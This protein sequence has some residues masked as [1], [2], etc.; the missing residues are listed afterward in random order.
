[1]TENT[2]ENPA[3]DAVLNLVQ[4][5][6]EMLNK[7]LGNVQQASEAQRKAAVASLE[8]FLT[9][10]EAAEQAYLE[11]ANK[12]LENME[13]WVQK[14]TSMD[15]TSNDFTKQFAEFQQ[16][17]MNHA[18]TEV[19]HTMPKTLKEMTDAQ[20]ALVYRAFELVGQRAEPVDEN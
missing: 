16:G 14:L 11:Q 9:A 8:R 17:L 6:H 15:Y 20:I 12:G 13:N 3:A 10:H 4:A 18:Q 1:M 19:K 5:Q 2:A 7:L